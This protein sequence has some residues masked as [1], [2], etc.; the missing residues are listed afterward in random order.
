MKKGLKKVLSFVL[1]G[2]L[3]FSNA[4]VMSAEAAELT[5]S[6]KIMKVLDSG[7]IVGEGD[8]VDLSQN[9]TR[10]RAF[11]MLVRLL[12][13]QDELDDFTYDE[14]SPTFADANDSSIS[15]FVAKLMAYLKATPE[16][17]VV[18][19]EDDTLRPYEEISSKE[20]VRVLLEALG[21]EAD[22]D[23]NWETVEFFASDLGLVDS[24]SDLSATE[25]INVGDIAVLT[26]N[27]LASNSKDSDVSLGE[28]LGYDVVEDQGETELSV[29][30]ISITNYKEVVVSF[31]DSLDTTLA[32]DLENYVV[33]VGTSEKTIDSVEID[34]S[35]AILNLAD[36]HEI[37]RQDNVSVTVK[38][39]IGIDEDVVKTINNV[40]D[41]TTPEF[42][43]ITI[44]GPETLEISFSEPL[45][46][47][48]DP[49]VLINNGAY[50]STIRE[51][52]GNIVEIGLPSNLEEDSYDL[53]I[54]DATDLSGLV[55]AD[56]D[57]SFTY[58]TVTE[59]VTAQVVSASQNEVVIEFDQK[60]AST[61][62]FSN[63]DFYYA[64]T[65]FNPDNVE[66]AEDRKT[67]TLTFDTYMIPE[68]DWN[69]TINMDSVESEWGNTASSD[70]TL[71]ISVLIDTK[72][73]SVSLDEVVS[74]NEIKLAFDETVKE[75]SAEDETNY[76]VKNSSNEDV[77]TGFTALYNNT[78]DTVTLAFARKLPGGSYTVT[79]K[80]IVDN[81]PQEN[82]MNSQDVGFSITDK[83]APEVEAAKIVADEN[84]IYVTFN[85]EMSSSVLDTNNWRYDNY[86][87][88]KVEFFG[89]NEKVKLTFDDDITYVDTDPSDTDNTLLVGQVSDTEDNKI[90]DL[91]TPITVDSLDVI[92]ILSAKSL[93]SNKVEVTLEGKIVEGIIADNF[94]FTDGDGN[95]NSAA[96]VSYS[97]T[98]EGN[99][100]VTAIMKSDVAFSA[101]EV[102]ASVEV[103]G[104]NLKADT[105]VTVTTTSFTNAED[106]IAPSFVEA[107]S[108]ATTTGAAIAFDEDLNA[109]STLSAL[110]AS[111]L[112]ITYEGETLVAG[113]DY[114]TTINS[115][116]VEIELLGDNTFET[117]KEVTISAS[118]IKYIQDA[119]SL[120]NK[121][122]N[123]SVEL[124]VE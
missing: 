20:Y 78:D 60:L 61:V 96:Y 18:G 90:D 30:S 108:T 85:E 31:N 29:N 27:S 4:P 28:K 76:T 17:G 114:E 43:D 67:A 104:D 41:Y 102:P 113:I 37:T 89:S 115:N 65:Q 25:K 119:N 33:A 69:L 86:K 99:T 13:R 79:V 72:A 35:V 57:A 93:T 100:V 3:L 45:D 24:S 64:Y 124:T 52:K 97:Y 88:S 73:P 112:T 21:Y 55:M 68:G 36:G 70:I 48:V 122:N 42:E 32:N 92:S 53:T 39:E 103:L 46:E 58:T 19:Y 7:V 47:N 109:D 107:D 1:A 110:I 80:D 12:G 82:K 34:D 121:A 16:V 63:N 10:Y 15:P 22:V 40:I 56:T 101:D 5:E 94:I 44:T 81:T 6:E 91:Q 75:S 105:G 59:D 14:S 71:P 11:T 111:E 66:L 117:E 87:P 98:S 51:V 8:G 49:V 118:S 83:T 106:G 84:I 9:L 2:L 23:Y 123:F 120:N 116:L 50:S 77:T 62:S 38:E 95:T 26:Y 54:K 74:E